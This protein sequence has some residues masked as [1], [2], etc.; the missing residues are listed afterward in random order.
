M[1]WDGTIYL[2]GNGGISSNG[3]LLGC[4]SGTGVPVA[5]SGYRFFSAGGYVG[6]IGGWATYTAF[7]T[8]FPGAWLG[9][10]A[11]E[12]FQLPSSYSSVVDGG[13]MRGHG[14]SHDASDG[15]VNGKLFNPHG[16]TDFFISGQASVELNTG[17]DLGKTASA[18]LQ[19]RLMTAGAYENL[20]NQSSIPPFAD[21]IASAK[22]NS[23]GVYQMH[24]VAGLF[25]GSAASMLPRTAQYPCVPIAIGANSLQYSNSGDFTGY[26]GYTIPGGRSSEYQG[27]TAKARWWTASGFAPLSA[28]GE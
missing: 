5:P 27:Q 28:Y 21:G 4:A 2:N 17:R 7:N 18:N 14:V 22:W 23:A 13:Y 10:V 26:Y 20:P 1:S 9:L 16:A 11:T 12:G 24:P 19:L 3:A 8:L 25:T 15:Y 6:G